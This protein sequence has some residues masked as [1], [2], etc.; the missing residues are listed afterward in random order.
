MC[1]YVNAGYELAAQVL[2]GDLPPPDVIF[3]PAGLL[4]TTS[5][6]LVGLR[7][8]GLA[9]K[10]VAV[11]HHWSRPETAAADLVRI[12][13]LA[14]AVCDYLRVLAPD[15]PISPIEPGDV[16]LAGPDANQPEGLVDSGMDSAE[17]LAGEDDVSIEPTWT[18]QVIGE[19]SRRAAAGALDGKSVLY[20]H[21]YNSRQYPAE[22]DEISYKRLPAA[23]WPHF[24]AQTLHRFNRPASG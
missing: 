5:G 2:V 24:E 12:K 22:A 11:S 13:V 10:V 3:I 14:E 4:G 7:A 18:A 19:I 17:L 23:F 20:W 21:T 16:T 1:G 9:T 6:L 8:A 15:F